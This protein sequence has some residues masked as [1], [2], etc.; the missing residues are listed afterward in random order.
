MQAIETVYNGYRFRSRLEARWAVFFDAMGIKYQYEPEGFKGFND[1]PYLPDFYLPDLDI[2]VEVKGSRQ[3]LI[4][5]S[6]KIAAAIDFNSTPIAKKG[7]LILG[8][9]PNPEKIE[10]SNI[11]MFYYLEWDEG[12]KL[13]FAA[14]VAI[15]GRPG[16]LAKGPKNI[17]KFCFCYPFKQTSSSYPD[18]PDSVYNLENMWTVESLIQHPYKRVKDAYTKARQARFEHGEKP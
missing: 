17:F 16:Y 4:E 2:Y 12:I 1:I 3:A 13:N 6:E 5:D 8:D 7:L 14:F 18:L 10:K 15:P 9:I 11:P